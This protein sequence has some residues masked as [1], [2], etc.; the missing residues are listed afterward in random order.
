MQ[1]DRSEYGMGK[2]VSEYQFQHVW[3]ELCDK[4]S[5]LRLVVNVDPEW[6]KKTS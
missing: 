2:Q 1:L 6:V 4:R 5:I 3:K